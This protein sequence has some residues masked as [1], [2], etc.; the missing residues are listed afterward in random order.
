MIK[1]FRK[2]RFNHMEKNKTGKYFKYAIGEIILVVIGI[3]IALSIN[4][5]NE[6]RKENSQLKIALKSVYNELVLDSLLIHNQL[7]DVNSKLKTNTDL[8]TKVYAT[9]TN[10]DTLIKVMK[11]EFPMRWYASP[12]YNTNTFSNLKSTGGFDL[13][14]TDI[15]KS[16]SKYYTAVE[17][18][19]DLNKELLNQ[20]RNHL[21]DF[22]KHYNI[23]G[24]F[25]DD[26]YN[27]SYLYNSTW[28]NIDEKDFTPRVAVL[29]AAYQVLY[30]NAKGEL[31]TNQKNIKAILPQ[32][33]PYLD[34]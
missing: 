22:V 15:K 16:L 29:L 5:W 33:K 27:N 34:L 17:A 9:T 24:R 20:Y 1:F 18:G 21:D 23:I 2:I 28:T 3:L 32:L 4:N 31:E 7:P 11:N 30:G 19:K 12:A 8:I 25:Y 13:L 10:I 26:N 14:P 6:S